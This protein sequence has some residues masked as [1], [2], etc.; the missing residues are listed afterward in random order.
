MKSAFGQ[1][2]FFDEIKD[3][4]NE[5]FLDKLYKELRYE[6][7]SKRSITFNLGDMGRKFY[8]ILKGTVSILLKKKGLEQNADE[9]WSEIQDDDS[10][11]GKEQKRKNQMLK[12]IL[13]AENTS[14]FPAEILELSDEQYMTIRFPSF[15]V[16]RNMKDGDSFGEVA[17]RQNVAR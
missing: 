11:V 13:E 16:M 5:A 8:I 17:L 12:K 15:F 7:G 14:V 6:F 4:L 10:L 3:E 1:V 2:K 9:K